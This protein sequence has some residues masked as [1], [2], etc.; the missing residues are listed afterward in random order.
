MASQG[1]KL[2]GRALDR[3]SSPI[4]WRARELHTTSN[5]EKAPKR[6]IIKL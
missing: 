2:A 3:P 4:S 1:A 6:Y 5:R